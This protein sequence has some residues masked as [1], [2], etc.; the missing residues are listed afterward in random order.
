MKIERKLEVCLK[1]NEKSPS[2]VR[3][4]SQLT[5]ESGVAQRRPLWAEANS[6]DPSQFRTSREIQGL[7]LGNGQG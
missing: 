6:C 2:A 5:R 1:N 3:T 7:F 4:G